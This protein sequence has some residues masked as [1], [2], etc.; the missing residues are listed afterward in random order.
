MKFGQINSKRLEKIQIEAEH[1][2]TGLPCYML[3]QTLFIVNGMGKNKC[4]TGN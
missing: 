4:K 2:V 3:V 1:I